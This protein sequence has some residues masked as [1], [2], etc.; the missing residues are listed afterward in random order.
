MNTNSN[1]ASNAAGDTPDP[2]RFVAAPFAPWD[3]RGSIRYE[4][5]A[6]M[7][8]FLLA[9]GVSGVFVNGTTGEGL[10]LTLDER[11]RL[12]ETWREKS[13][14]KLKLFVHVGH[15]CPEDARELA[16]HA[17]SLKADAI[18]AIGP[19]FY[20]LSSPDVLA[21]YCGRIAEAAPGTP[22]YYYHLPSMSRVDCLASAA[23]QAMAGAVPTF[24]GIKFTH[25]DIEDYRR[26]LDLAGD[27]FEIMF[28][29]DELL[30]EG[31]KAGA[32]SAVGSTYNFA[33]PLYR[34]IREAF[35]SG[36]HAEAQALQ[37]LATDAINLMVAA[38]GQPG[39][40]AV[41]TMEGI[42][43]GGVRLPMQGLDRKT[44]GELQAALERLAY[45]EQIRA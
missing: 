31:L 7:A 17:E 22:F 21:A 2:F 24:A 41:L 30:L 26:C 28:G 34:K 43:F 39:I 4:S 33:V 25:N 42:D 14:G 5:V 11:K 23:L 9:R 8:D 16:R 1:P 10:S 44:S 12:A 40:K 37:T 27:R 19:V 3:E 38:G 13:A 18:A 15:A 29:R 32:R 45:F 6:P 36:K 20:G 35:V